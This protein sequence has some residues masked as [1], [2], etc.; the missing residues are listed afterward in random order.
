MGDTPPPQHNS[1]TVILCSTT[2]ELRPLSL[3]GL[4]SLAFYLHLVDE[5]VSS[6]LNENEYYFLFYSFLLVMSEVF[7]TYVWGW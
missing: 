4:P 1:S 5:L 2:V 3:C 7:F 6:T